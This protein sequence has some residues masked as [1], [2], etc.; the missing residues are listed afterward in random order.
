ME[1]EQDNKTFTSILEMHWK[2]K[3]LFG[4]LSFAAIASFLQ[5][6]FAWYTLENVH[7]QSLIPLFILPIA[8]IVGIV[9]LYKTKRADYVAIGL[10]LIT[11]P[12]LALRSLDVG[13]IYSNI[14]LWFYV[15][16]IFTAFYSGKKGLIITTF[17]AVF[18]SAFITYKTGINFEQNITNATAFGVWPRFFFFTSPLIIVTFIVYQKLTEREKFKEAVEENQRKTLGE[19]KMVTLGEMSAQ[20]A[21][22][23]NNPLTLLDAQA[24]R[25]NKQL[26]NDPLYTKQI[27]DIRK[28]IARMS[29]VVRDIHALS[30]KTKKENFELSSVSEIL[31][32]I[33]SLYEYKMNEVDFEVTNSAP[34][35]FIKCQRSLVGQVILNLIFNALE[36][37]KETSSPKISLK[38]TQK[39]NSLLIEMND[40]GKGIPE[41][42]KDDIFLPYFTTKEL[43]VGSGIG[44]SVCKTIMDVHDGMIDFQSPPGKG[45]QF[46]LKFP[47]AN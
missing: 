19:V 36:A 29:N 11:F 6:L 17:V 7:L 20:I 22:E 34:D 44:L 47:I 40:N 38:V 32:E 12:L 4:V 2:V 42:I 14:V 37:V 30:T 16:P 46:V 41:S 1:R 45:T 39:E 3:I 24:Y 21:H 31:T 9:F 18:L 13:G 15:L 23:L 27:E 35:V 33:H 8:L 25:L 43:G 10:A 28:T 26:G 5:T